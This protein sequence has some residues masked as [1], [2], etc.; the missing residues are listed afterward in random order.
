[1]LYLTDSFVID[2]SETREDAALKSLYLYVH[3]QMMNCCD[4]HYYYHDSNRMH[5]DIFR[6]NKP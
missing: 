2:T 5:V 3:I 4:Y 1:M 6:R